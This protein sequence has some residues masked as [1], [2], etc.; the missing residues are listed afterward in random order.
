MD[1]PLLNLKT[2]L[3]SSSFLYGVH[4]LRG[5]AILLVLCDHFLPTLFPSGFVGVDIFF[6]I[7]GYLITRSLLKNPSIN[8][9][10]FIINFYKQRINRILPVL[11]SSVFIIS[12]CTML[13]SPSPSV[14]LK[15][16]AT[17]LFGVS[18]IF[19]INNSSD[20]FAES[21]HFNTFLQTWSLSVEE[22]FYLLYPI[23]F[24]FAYCFLKR[25]SLLALV[26]II[27]VSYS[28]FLF[29][30][31]LPTSPVFAYYSLPTRFW[32]LATGCLLSLFTSQV[33]ISGSSIVRQFSFLRS[34]LLIALFIVALLPAE[35][36]FF[37]HLVAVILSSF[38]IYLSLFIPYKSTDYLVF[39]HFADISFSWYIW[40]WSLLSLSLHIFSS[41]FFISLLVLPISYVVSLASWQYLESLPRIISISRTIIVFVS[42]L[43]SLIAVSS[44]LLYAIMRKTHLFYLG[45]LDFYINSYNPQCLY[46]KSFPA[47]QI[48][49]TMIASKS[50][51]KIHIVG[52]SH[53]SH[54][55]SLAFLLLRSEYSSLTVTSV[56]GQPF[57]SNPIIRTQDVSISRQGNIYQKLIQAQLLSYAS[58]GDVVVIANSG[59]YFVPPLL[60]ASSES[61]SGY[62]YYS[63]FDYKTR[64]SYSQFVKQ[65]IE[66]LAPFLAL[67]EKRGVDVFY[68][69]PVPSFSPTSFSQCNP[70]L[71]VSPPNHYCTKTIRL[72]NH[73]SRITYLEQSLQALKVRSPNLLLYDP[74]P[75][76]CDQ[77]LCRRFIKKQL[78]VDGT[79]LSLHGSLIVS[80]DFL[81]KSKL[82]ND[83]K[84]R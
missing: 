18:N 68:F 51:R 58:P 84:P 34:S 16:A 81:E 78:F 48:S 53:A 83:L 55:A 59:S 17:A 5:I 47:C 67:A 25:K 33:S 40:H 52:D 29:C 10:S 36:A 74:S 64:V 30:I 4:V 11:V 60:Y 41:S 20:Y 54:Y 19:L 6:V 37:P 82:L 14:S 56:P 32:G 73:L 26:L 72:V 76:F 57:P 49:S 63:A 77:S 13:V 62:E 66:S 79:H 50:S 8:F 69:L 39:Q 44:F 23:I 61:E 3:R 7:S 35:S 45:N 65:F 42:G 71:N 75:I 15:T 28:L 27:L 12:I 80:K 1:T 43:V 70:M 46:Q 21:T 9:A 31:K 2:N 24:W 38:F 22:Q